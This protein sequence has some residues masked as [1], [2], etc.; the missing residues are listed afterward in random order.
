ML[1]AIH[2]SRLIGPQTRPFPYS[3]M[4]T[5]MQA[6]LLL[7]ASHSVDRMVS[8]MGCFP[9]RGSLFKWVSSALCYT[10]ERVFLHSRIYVIYV[11][12]NSITGGGV[13]CTMCYSRQ[14][15]VLTCSLL[16]SYDT[17]FLHSLEFQNALRSTYSRMFSYHLTQVFNCRRFIYKAG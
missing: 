6:K 3:I 14:A 16:S 4:E 10:K 17:R 7:N 15:C 11:I 9:I 1:T 12:M 2:T 5:V 8:Q 13:A